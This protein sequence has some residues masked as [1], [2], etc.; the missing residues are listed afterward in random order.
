MDTIRRLIIKAL[1][2][3]ATSLETGNPRA[4]REAISEIE[5]DLQ[6]KSDDRK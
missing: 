1:K 5:Q 3:V 6:E 2:A 4:I